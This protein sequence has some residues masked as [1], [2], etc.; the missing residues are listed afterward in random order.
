[1]QGRARTIYRGVAVVHTPRPGR[2]KK[3]GVQRPFV[4]VRMPKHLLDY[5]DAKVDMGVKRTDALLDIL[6]L[7]KDL[8]EAMGS[9]FWELERQAKVA[10]VMPG[11]LLG[12]IACAALDKKRR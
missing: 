9:D 7:A 11:T 4:G 5:I 10:G 12:Q 2:E 6:Q 3:R 1:M 8:E